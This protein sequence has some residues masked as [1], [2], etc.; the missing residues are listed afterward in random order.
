MKPE[1]LL[2][3]LG[4]LQVACNQEVRLPIISYT[5]AAKASCPGDTLNTY[6]F[7]QP[8]H[9]VEKMPLLLVL[10][11][12]GDGLLAVEK[13]QPA[14]FR[15]ACV[16]MGSDLVRNNYTGYD[17]AIGALIQEAIQRFPVSKDKIFIAGFSGGARMALEYARQ[18]PVSGVLMCGAG[19]GNAFPDLPSPVYMIAGTTDFN[20]SEMYY[21]PLR[22]SGRQ[23]FMSDYFRGGHEWPPAEKLKDALLLLMADVLP[24]RETLFLCESA[25][26]S[27]K[28]DSMMGG[29]ELLFA[30]KTVEKAIRFNPHNKQAREQM[31]E[32]KNST[33]FTGYFNRIESDLSVEARTGQ[34]YIQASMEKDSIWWADEIRKLTLEIAGSQGD[35]KDHFERIKGFIGIL[36]YSQL[37]NLLH[38]QSGNPQIPHLLAAYKLAEPE[39][40]DVYNF[41]AL[42]DWKQGKEQLGREELSWAKAMGFSD[43]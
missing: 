13:I 37:N 3:L 42:Y 8:E 31:K 35:K 10:D 5:K 14:V 36:F 43:L 6:H 30:V 16:V 18:H 40:P 41:R 22:E 11:S 28:A 23:E 21:N 38:V 26:L 15:F 27:E 2:F 33:E 20:F 25:T 9:P 19:P 24:G 34:A 29:K 32:I 1:S 39:N 4:I 7:I 12:G 17:R